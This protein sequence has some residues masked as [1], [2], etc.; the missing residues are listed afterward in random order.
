ME[1]ASPLFDQR[2]A[3]HRVRH[4]VLKQ[5][6][7]SLFLA[8]LA[9]ASLSVTIFFAYNC[10]LPQ[11][12][13]TRLMPQSPAKSILV[14]NF[15]SQIAMFCL[16]ELASCVLGVLGWAFA[17]HPSGTPAYTFLA[18]SRATNLAGVLYLI[19]GKGPKPGKLQRDGHR[20]WGIQRYVPL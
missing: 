20:I 11:P 3:Q 13:S 15:L 7:F 12:L 4:H 14:L 16:A 2:P 19:T 9:V 10:S 1:A 18:L 8:V 5:R 6:S 17:S